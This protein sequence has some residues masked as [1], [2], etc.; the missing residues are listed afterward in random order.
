MPAAPT[1]QQELS[2]SRSLAANPAYARDARYFLGGILEGHPKAGDAILCLSE[3]A[4]NAIVHSR[5]R[6]SG[7]AF[8]V[9]VQLNGQR[10]RVEVCDQ[11]G[12]W[13][14]PGQASEDDQSGRGLLIVGQLSSRW[15]CKEHSHHGR[16]VWFELDTC[17]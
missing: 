11:G 3:L 15:G 17:L 7:G 8:T 14:S 1:T 2:H 9:R 10:L 4:A 6:Q 13:H 5:S 12:L 16:T